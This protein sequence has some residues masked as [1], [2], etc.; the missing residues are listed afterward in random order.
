MW[1]SADSRSKFP[2][3]VP[4]TALQQ[5]PDTPAPRGRGAHGFCQ[6][7]C[8]TAIRALDIPVV[9][10]GG[11]PLHPLV[12][13]AA[14]VL[15]PLAALGGLLMASAGSRSKRY[16]PLIATVAVVAALAAFVSAASGDVLRDELGLRNQQHFE[17][18]EWLPWVALAQAV[19][20]TLLFILDRQ[21]GGKRN[22]MSLIVMIATVLLAVASI[23]LT[24]V[25][26]HTGA[27]LVWG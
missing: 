13:H 4:H 11:M 3:P 5:F 9:D 27:E 1:E 21:T 19:A 14:V 16:G 2:E 22:P 23:G 26:G 12:V 25:T 18:G 7:R 15:I 20:V 6:T 10:V 17:Y 24:V 8:V